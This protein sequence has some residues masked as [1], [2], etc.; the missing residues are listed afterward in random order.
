M[1]AIEIR[2]LVKT[3]GS[4]CRA[5]DG[6]SLRLEQGEMAGLIGASGSGKSTLLRH[7]SGLAIADRGSTSGVD[8]LATRVQA[9]GRPG[10]GVRRLRVRVGI[11]FQ[12][13]NLVPR[14][15]LFTNVLMGRLGRLPVWR[16]CLGWF[17]R[18][19]QQAAMA[20]LA[21]VG[22]AAYANQRAATL[23]G[24]Q[25]QRGAIA[26]ALFQGAEVL[27]ADEPI[28]SLDPG[29][30]RQVMDTL[31]A[32]NREDGITVLVSLHQ[33]EYA[34]H[35]CPRIVAMA[36]GR[37]VYDGASEALTARFLEEL[38]GAESET[39]LLSDPRQPPPRT[40]AADARERAAV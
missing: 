29:A 39:L 22:M 28:A 40:A 25:Q 4:R 33:V 17:T 6:V 3:F 23:S 1:A 2:N 26:R 27:V 20:A 14:L 21:R 24:G 5:V 37:V 34:M 36:E 13:F 32:L 15:S 11:I 38:Y 31:A 10:R 19:E 16:G 9:N 7:V 30:A 12:Q 8:V 18:E 35:Y